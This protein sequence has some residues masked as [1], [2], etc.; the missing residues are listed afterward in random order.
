MSLFQFMEKLSVP[1][2]EKNAFTI[3]H[4]S[5]EHFVLDLFLDGYSR[6]LDGLRG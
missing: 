5:A 6:V 2:K 3:C 4:D 1:Y